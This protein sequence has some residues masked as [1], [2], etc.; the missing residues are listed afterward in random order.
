MCTGL[1]ITYCKTLLCTVLK[2]TRDIYGI[3]APKTV[4]P[5]QYLDRPII[6]PSV[7]CE[8]ITHIPCKSSS[9]IAISCSSEK[10]LHTVYNSSRIFEPLSHQRVFKRFQYSGRLVIM[11]WWG[12]L[13]FQN[14]T[15]PHL[16][17]PDKMPQLHVKAKE[18]DH[19]ISMPE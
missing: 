8:S 5:G 12:P 16:S 18:H 2:L 1:R 7:H 13:L 15:A 6:L 14:R 4:A 9:S 3:A 10:K 11:R 17:S 19:L